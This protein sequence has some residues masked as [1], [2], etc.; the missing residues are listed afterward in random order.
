MQY[1]SRCFVHWMAQIRCNVISAVAKAL[2]LL[3]LYYLVLLREREEREIAREGKGGSGR[4]FFYPS[5]EH[6][7]ERVRAGA[8]VQQS[9]T[10]FSSSS[11]SSSSDSP[12]AHGE[13]L[14]PSCISIPSSLS[15]YFLPSILLFHALSFF[16]SFF[17]IIDGKI[18]QPVRGFGY[19]CRFPPQ[20]RGKRTI[21]WGVIF[22][23]KDSLFVSHWG[24]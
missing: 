19:H 21:F 4:S 14:L 23:V 13:L 10:S 6:S 18:D 12:H 17:L 2:L 20:F 3:Y 15:H 9:D 7:G 1:L 8:K 11:S 16:L 22:W 5:H 24:P